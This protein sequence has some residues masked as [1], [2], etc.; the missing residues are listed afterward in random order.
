MFVPILTSL[1]L[2]WLYRDDWHT[3]FKIGRAKYVAL[4]FVL[5][6]MAFLVYI[7]AAYLSSAATFG[8]FHGAI[9]IN[10]GSKLLAWK[11]LFVM[12]LTYLPISLLFAVG[13]EAGWR[14]YFLRLLSQNHWRTLLTRAVVVGLAWGIWHIPDYI[15]AGLPITNM[16]I[17][18]VNV[19]LISIIIT[20]L[21]EQEY[22]VAPAIMLHGTHNLLFNVVLPMCQH[23]KTNASIWLGEEGLAVTV[24]YLSLIGVVWLI[25]EYE[26]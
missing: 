26:K 15:K 4:G 8:L 14:G 16:V 19:V 3:L 9:I 11:S 6:T 13:E 17:F 25:K 7:V 1:L 22:A 10:H 21:F 12:G 18:V 2:S 20:Y 5:P 23:P 24:A